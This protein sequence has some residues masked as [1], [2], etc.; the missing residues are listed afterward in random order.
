MFSELKV[1]EYG[2]RMGAKVSEGDLEE[3]TFGM[4]TMARVSRS[5]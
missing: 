1:V 4:K 2:S 3:T 5:L